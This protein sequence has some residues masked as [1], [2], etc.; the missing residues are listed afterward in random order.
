MWVHNNHPNG[1]PRS[2]STTEVRVMTENAP[3]KARL[4]AAETGRH[5]QK[6]QKGVETGPRGKRN[7]TKRH[8]KRATKVMPIDERDGGKKSVAKRGTPRAETIKH[9][10]HQHG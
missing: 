6:R 9:K 7:H 4:P 8:S 10:V 5:I 1:V 2:I 3:L